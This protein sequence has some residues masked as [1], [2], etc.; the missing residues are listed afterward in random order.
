MK[1]VTR[2]CMRRAIPVLLVV[3]LLGAI[4]PAMGQ[5]EAPLQSVEETSTE[6]AY[7]VARRE[8]S[9]NDFAGY[10]FEQVVE[11]VETSVDP[12]QQ[13]ISGSLSLFTESVTQAQELLAED[14]TE[15]ALNKVSVAIGAVLANRDKVLGPMWQGQEYL[16]EQIGK[17]RDRLAQSIKAGGGDTD[18]RMD[19]RTEVMLDGIAERISRE[20]DPLRKKRLVAHYRTIRQ[21]ARIKQMAKQ[22]S[23]DQQ[24]LWLNVLKVMENTTLTHQRVLM[25]TEVLFAQLEATA[26]NLRGYQ[27]LVDTVGGARKL[28]GVVGGLSDSGQGLAKVSQ[29]MA[30]LQKNLT[31][32]DEQIQHTLEDEMFDL[33]AQTDMIESSLEQGLGEVGGDSAAIDDELGARLKKFASAES[34]PDAVN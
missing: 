16:T 30:A 9:A 8:N 15:E 23:P 29:T 32:F 10:D 6:Q 17:I 34:D 24:K 13:E 7:K 22:L 14:R 27:G 11:C 33:D 28:L 19:K 12:L 21:L 31:G 1:H 4:S 26:A 25:G 2:A 3:V 18:E 20:P 5:N